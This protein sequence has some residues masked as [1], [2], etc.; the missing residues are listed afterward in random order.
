PL[1]VHRRLH[2]ALDPR[3]RSARDPTAAAVV[4]RGRLRVPVRRE[5]RD[6]AGRGLR[7]D[8]SPRRAAARLRRARRARAGQR[9]AGRREVTRAVFLDRDGTLN[10]EVGFVTRP[11]SLVVLPGVRDA[12]AQL[13]GAG[14][15][16]VVVTNQSGIARGL[17]AESDLA[18]INARLHDEI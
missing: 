14:F 18:H 3:R 15:R 10:A 13:H 1:P 7:A 2:V 11:E 12:L 17:Y 5:G 6:R 9:D 4:D 8:A 16:L